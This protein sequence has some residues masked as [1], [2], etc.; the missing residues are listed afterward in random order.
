MNAFLHFLNLSLFDDSYIEVHVFL[1][2]IFLFRFRKDV[3]GCG[4]NNRSKISFNISIILL[5]KKFITHTR[6][7]LVKCITHLKKSKIKITQNNIS[8]IPKIQKIG[9]LL[10]INFKKKSYNFRNQNVQSKNS[11]SK[12]RKQKFKFSSIK[13]TFQPYSFHNFSPTNFFYKF[14][15]SIHH[16]LHKTK[17]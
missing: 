12:K 4:V 2:S 1:S 13:L 17:I 9:K 16:F 7:L 8:K 6:A 3:F 14:N 10:L 15:K 5:N 11:S